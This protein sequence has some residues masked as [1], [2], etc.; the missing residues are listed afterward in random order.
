[1][2][3]SAQA[4]LETE[5][6][7]LV[8]RRG[9]DPIAEP[10]VVARLVEEVV[11]DYR[12]RAITST[13]PPL[14]DAVATTRTVLD[15]VAGF[16]PLQPLLDDP[17]VE[18]LWINEP[19]RVFVARHG[20]SELTNLILT[21]DE[22][23]ELVERM[24]R[25][26]GRR[27]DLSTPFVDAM[28]PDGSRLHVVIPTITRKHMAVNIRKFAV[29]LRSLDELVAIGTLTEQAARFLEASVIAGLNV[30]VAGG[31]QAGKTTL[32]NALCGAIPA[33]ERV[34]TV[35]EVFELSLHAPDVVAM[36]TRQANLEG[37]GEIP[38]RRLVKEA[39]RMRPSRLVV[40]EVRQE[41]C[42]DLLIALNSGLPGMCT[43]HAN[44]AREAL[45]K[46]CTLPLLAGE[47]IAAS[48]VV[49]TVATSVDLVVHLG[50]TASGARRVREIV[51]VTGRVEADVIETA[52]IFSSRRGRLERSDGF[53]PHPE[54][55]EAA[56]IDVIHA[57]GHRADRLRSAAEL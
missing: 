19:G 45:V 17:T 52:E 5:V 41:E 49:P 57:L 40:G 9:I 55:Y 43:L 1:V 2:A 36:Q 18:E 38:L 48:F 15:A 27:I 30:L 14:G 8:R 31:T 23:A 20:R 16:G 29:G 44:S 26:T 25:P 37:T 6:R 53:P 7:E 34:V 54:R 42:L 28:L 10:A 13:L 4:I 39:L 33:R 32:L 50:L 3:A 12:D 22:V 11:G 35:E 47:N 21:A 51:G 46:M 24:L 56:G